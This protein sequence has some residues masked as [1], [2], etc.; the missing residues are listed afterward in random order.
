M[1]ATLSDIFAHVECKPNQ[2]RSVIQTSNA[3]MAT[4][5]WMCVGLDN[6][7]NAST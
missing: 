6:Q 2:F 1:S 4:L 7:R 3:R 5:W